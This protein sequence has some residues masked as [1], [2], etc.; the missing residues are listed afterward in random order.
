MD[1]LTFV[2]Q[3]PHGLVT[4]PIYRKDAVMPSGKAATGKNPHPDAF[5]RKFEAADTALYIERDPQN[6]KAVGLFTGIR[7]NGIVILDVDR[8]LSALQQKWG[9]SLEGAPRIES[10]KANA[11]KFVFRIQEGLWG[12][13]QGFGLSEDTGHCYEVLWGRQ[14]VIYGEYP[15]GKV[16]APGQYGFHGDLD[17]IPEAPEWLIAE[18]K[19]A[20]AG[21]GKGLV[22]NRKA[23]DLGDRTEDEVA[24]IIQECLSVISHQGAGSREHWVRIGMA[25]HSALPT[26]LGL[27]LWAAWSAED[28]EYSEEW[29][30]GNPCEQTWQ[31]FKAGGRIGLGTLIFLADREDPKRLRF[32]ERSRDIVEKAEARQVQEVRQAVLTFEEIIE[33]GMKI[34]EGDDVARMNYELHALAMEARYKDQSG[35]EKL[36]LDHI[37]QTATGDGYT[38]DKRRGQRRSYLI[39]GL[40]PS[41]YTVLFHGDKGTGK[42]ATA[43]AL[44]KHVL[45]GIPFQ[46]NNQRVPVAPGKAIYFSADMSEQDFEEEFELHE[47]RNEQNLRFQPGFNLYRKMQF[48]KLMNSFKP[49]IIVID[50]LSSCSGAKAGDENKAEF[51]QPLY[52][53][54]TNNGTL[55]PACAMVI[56]HHSNKAT[57]GARG[58]SAIGAAV[59]E[60]W[61]ITKPKAD[62]GLSLQDQRVIHIGKSRIGREGESLIQT[63]NE[64][65]TISLAESKR[66]EE[67]QTRAGTVA[68]R[69]M[70]RLVTVGRPMTQKELN[71]DP[72]VGGSVAAIQKTLQ[73]LVN[74]G[75]VEVV[76]E[77]QRSS[78]KGGKKELAYQALRGESSRVSGSEQ[79]P[80]AGTHLESDT[81]SETQGCPIQTGVPLERESDNP[82]PEGECPIE[83]VSAGAGSGHNRTDVDSIR[84]QRSEAELDAMRDA[85]WAVWEDEP[86][87]MDKW[88]SLGHLMDFD[89]C[90]DVVAKEMP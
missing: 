49:D 72:L 83:E 4:A 84:N 43:F 30:S 74:R 61:N 11:A 54:N 82:S 80:S 46:L 8:N 44:L 55:W 60:I 51:A 88:D 62:S 40:L 17:A 29:R 47:I 27:T 81:P 1:L 66:P 22:K 68:E 12:D 33:R 59:A 5:Q 14:G 15:G 26:E 3:L 2:R 87:P 6:L 31:S 41:P 53:L 9:S 86:K 58:S 67:M 16:S 19:A 75:V 79:T 45:D 89:G 76:E 18:M 36:L 24:E 39:P 20:K 52:W 48:V 57:G 37:A 63:Q 56:I 64:D 50:S 65:L 10:T 42:S 78:Q 85:A 71:A 28:P 73:R 7:G 90:I 25:I 35:I 34:Y 38:M 32:S 69:I 13:L 23:L 70:N 21:E 77:R